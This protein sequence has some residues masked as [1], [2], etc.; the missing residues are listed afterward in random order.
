MRELPGTKD[1][2]HEAVTNV[3]S[4]PLPAFP[5]A[6]QTPPKQQVGPRPRP[7]TRRGEST[8]S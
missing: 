2:L 1:A 3:N 6:S 4:L 8:E 7:R 5:G